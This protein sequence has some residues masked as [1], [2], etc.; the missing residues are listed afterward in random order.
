MIQPNEI[1]VG[2]KIRV[3]YNKGIHVTGDL[4]DPSY[5]KDPDVFT[6][7]KRTNFHKKGNYRL[8]LTHENGWGSAVVIR[9]DSE[10]W[11]EEWYFV[12][13]V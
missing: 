2:D 7:T 11:P 4:W 12:T 9:F 10:V 13:K 1:K 3:E 5:Q 8:Y 6:V